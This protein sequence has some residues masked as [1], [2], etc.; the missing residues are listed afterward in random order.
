[1]REEELRAIIEA[2]GGVEVE[3]R[4]D[5]FGSILSFKRNGAIYRNAV[6]SGVPDPMDCLADWANSHLAN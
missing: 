1:M 3:F 4:Y 6:M 2:S 5:G